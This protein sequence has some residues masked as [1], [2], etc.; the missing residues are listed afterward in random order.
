VYSTIFN[1]KHIVLAHA[2]DIVALNQ[3]KVH[4]IENFRRIETEARKF[5]L[6]AN[7]EKA[8]VMQL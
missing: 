5:G 2:D 1:K 8:T 4:M 6:I 3:S 7:D